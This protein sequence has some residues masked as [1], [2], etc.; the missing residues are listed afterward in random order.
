MNEQARKTP[1]VELLRS[2]P[3]DAVWVFSDVMSMSRYPVGKWCHEAAAEIA[4]HEAA[5]F[6]CMRDSE[7]LREKLGR[8][9]GFILGWTK[10]VG[11]PQ[12]KSWDEAISAAEQHIY[13]LR[14]ALR[15]E[16]DIAAQAM[17]E[18]DAYQASSE[19]RGANI[20]EMQKALIDLSA[21]FA[22]QALGFRE[23]AR[24]LR[25]MARGS[26]DCSP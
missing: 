4:G 26:L 1:L 25:K 2:V 12:L 22:G 21:H 9:L 10:D 6:A 8:I 20:I 13:D 5:K 14:G 7:A 15:A 3:R 17:Q 19:I 18:R 23:I 16:S 11:L 24:E